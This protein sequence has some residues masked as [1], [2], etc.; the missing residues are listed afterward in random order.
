MSIRTFIRILSLAIGLVLASLLAWSAAGPLPAL[1]GAGLLGLSLG[2]LALLAGGG[3]LTRWQLRYHLDGEA[4]LDHLEQVLRFL[5]DKAGQFTFEANAAG[6]FLELPVAFDRYV[7][8]HL[9]KALLQL[10]MTKDKTGNE[11][12]TRGSSFFFVGPLGSDLLCWAT[13]EEGRQVRLHI[14]QGPYATLTAHTDGVRPP[15]RW[16]R[17]RMPRRLCQ[18]LPVWD[19]LSAGIRLSSLFPPTGDGA[20]YSSRSRLLQLVPPGDYHPDE[21]ARCLGQSTDDRQMTLSRA[22]PL[23]TAG[24]PSSFLARQALS[25]LETGRV[26]AV[27]SP[28][29]RVLE[30]IERE[31]GDC[32][33]YWLDPQNSRRSA[34]LPIVGA[35]EWGVVDVETVIQ[36]TQAFLAGLGLDVNLPVIGAFTRHLVHALASSA[37][38]TGTDFSFTDLYAVSQGTQ[39]LRAFLADVQDMAGE[40]GAQLLAHLDDDAG[41]VQAVTLLSAIR[42]A[43]KA[44]GTGLLH[45][46]CQPPFL[47]ASEALRGS[48]LLLVPMTN[49]DFPEHDR[50]LSAI[51]DLT[52]N[53]I[54][55]SADEPNLAL[56][57]HDPHLY[58]TD[59]G[60]QWA[61]AVRQE[62]RLSLL[63]DV[64][65]PESYRPDEQ[66][67]GQVVFR[68]SEAL[69]SSLIEG[70]GLPGSA[71]ELTELPAGMGMARLPDMVV[72][73]KVSE[74]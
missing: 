61:D 74:E 13:E 18:R 27:V 6:L 26:V 53:R 40:P 35:E 7:E 10:R 67:G 70:W 68:C 22:I 12:R 48:S 44:L 64:Q 73:L 28:H 20:V 45:A 15:G 56:H 58:R 4:D 36:V 59:R 72:I 41:Y 17:L 62:P 57:L 14:H 33:V 34:H 24:A 63:L 47:N 46:L 9:P 19:E 38:Q 51:L 2:Y 71:A 1:A 37:W 50:L 66:R 11:D 65:E 32:P 5:A 3:D 49:A 8:A 43:L 16:M 39:T 25:D 54:L 60:Q 21:N 30:Q 52:L 23:F 55:A 31:A 69:A 29:R 42:A